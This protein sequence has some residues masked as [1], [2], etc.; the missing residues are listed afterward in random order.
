MLIL[1]ILCNQ[2]VHCSPSNNHRGVSPP[3]SEFNTGHS[4]ASAITVFSTQ[5]SDVHEEMFHSP[6]LHQKV[7]PKTV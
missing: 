1:N 3:W 5:H 4:S 6:A 7:K 2:M